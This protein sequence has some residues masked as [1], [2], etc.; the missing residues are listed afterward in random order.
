M[1]NKE[2]K[3]KEQCCLTCGKLY[4]MTCEECLTYKCRKYEPI[5]PDKS[6]LSTKY[7]EAIAKIIEDG[8]KLQLLEME[9]KIAEK[10]DLISKIKPKT[11][12]PKGMSE[13]QF[14]N[15]LKETNMTPEDW[16]QL[17][18]Q[19]KEN[20]IKSIQKDVKEPEKPAI[21]KRN[22]EIIALVQQ[23]KG[24]KEIASTLNLKPETVEKELEY[25]LKNRM[26]KTVPS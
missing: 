10:T 25:I 20:I 5:Q 6:A 24:V 9:M 7:I 14:H 12:V 2:I 18:T 17:P 3:M 22:K 23:G 13:E 16:E 19:A 21:S 11:S 15:M 4:S 8:K 1:E 26:I